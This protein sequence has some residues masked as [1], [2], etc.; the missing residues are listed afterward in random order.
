MKNPVRTTLSAFSVSLATLGAVGVPA[1]VMSVEAAIAK[2]NN[3]NNGN[4]GNRGNSE[5]RGNS[6]N[7]GN[8]NNGGGNGNG[9]NASSLGSLNAGHASDTAQENAASNSRVGLIQA[10]EAAALATFMAQT[11]YDTAAS[12]FAEFEGFESTFDTLE[13]FV[14][15]YNDNSSGLDEEL[16]YWQAVQG[17][18]AADSALHSSKEIEDMAL[19]LAA[20]QET[21]EATIARLWDLLGTVA[22]Q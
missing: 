16:A 6:G 5:N 17:L 21:D 12:L 7:A 13:D 4:S 15:A 8:G 1:F 22:L 20:N 11:E 3:S 2:D 10:F 9:A 18:S 14:E 19:Q